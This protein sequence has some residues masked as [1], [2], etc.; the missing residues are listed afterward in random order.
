MVLGFVGGL[1]G[2]LF[3][4]PMNG[5]ATGTTN[6]QSFSEIVFFFTITPE[7]MLN[8]V[9]FAVVMGAIGGILPA[10]SAARKPIVETLREV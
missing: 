10:I 5:I 6:F 3:S 8:G 9:G 2:C 1:V 4:L 7:L